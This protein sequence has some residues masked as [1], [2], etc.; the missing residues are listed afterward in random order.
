VYFNKLENSKL[1]DNNV[2]VFLKDEEASKL[3]GQ[4]FAEAL[5]SVSSTH[6]GLIFFLQGDLGAGKSF[7]ARSVIQS[8]SSELM[9]KSPTYTLVEAYDLPINLT[10]SF[11]KKVQHFD[12]YRLCDSEEL[13]YLGIRELLSESFCSFIEWA[14]KGEG[15]LPSKPDLKFIF[16]YQDKARAVTVKPYTDK[17]V[18]LVKILADNIGTIFDR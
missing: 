13:E 17:G 2:S 11:Y 6:N 8:F 10:S 4:C 5:S 9:V 15:V 3:F 1:K 12:L 7:F 18:E 14:D 16:E